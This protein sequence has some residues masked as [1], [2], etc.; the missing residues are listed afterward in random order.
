MPGAAGNREDRLI[1]SAHLLRSSNGGDYDRI[2]V[3]HYDD[4][5][6]I[7]DRWRVPAAKNRAGERR[8]SSYQSSI[9]LF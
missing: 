8:G 1:G 3:G 5:G 6:W 4:L 9:P 7:I 2:K